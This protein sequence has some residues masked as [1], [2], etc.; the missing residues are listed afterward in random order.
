MA[1]ICEGA[2]ILTNI[3]QGA[4]V[5]SFRSHLKKL[6]LEKSLRD[7]VQLSQTRVAKDSGVSLPTVQRWYNGGFDRIDADTVKRLMS[8]F[9]C[10]LT[11][12]IEVA[13]E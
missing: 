12:L 5:A 11:E 8:Y 4:R 2:R 13:G 6:M 10:T 9:D 7:G 3:S 1:K